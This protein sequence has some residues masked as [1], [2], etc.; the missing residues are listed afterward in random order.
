MKLSR[1][2]WSR[3]PWY[4]EE[5]KLKKVTDSTLEK[6]F[7]PDFSSFHTTGG[8]S[9]K[10]TVIAVAAAAVGLAGCGS[11]NTRTAG[12]P[13]AIDP[14]MDSVSCDSE[15]TSPTKDTRWI[16]TQA[17]SED[18]TIG[19]TKGSTGS[20]IQL[21]GK[22]VMPKEVKL[23]GIVAAPDSPVITDDKE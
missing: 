20:E 6:P 7:Y 16:G 3:C 14:G 17:T 10:R 4:T 12:V 11:D 21:M 8:K 2:L 13:P 5:M 19:T 22:M 23:M 18:N 1:F 15:T 9:L